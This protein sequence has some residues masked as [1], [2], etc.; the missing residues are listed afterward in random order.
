[1]DEGTLA[2]RLTV[3]ALFRG[4]ELVRRGLARLAAHSMLAEQLLLKAGVD[5]DRLASERRRKD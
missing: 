1:M 2:E 4:A 5:V 3:P